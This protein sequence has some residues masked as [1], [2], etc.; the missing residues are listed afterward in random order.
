MLNPFGV[1]RNAKATAG[2]GDAGVLPEADEVEACDPGERHRVS[3]LLVGQ[4]KARLELVG[5]RLE[6]PTRQEREMSG[7]RRPV[8][9]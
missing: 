8:A 4:I 2:L 7:Y 5:R 3:R 9:V 1:R 6:I